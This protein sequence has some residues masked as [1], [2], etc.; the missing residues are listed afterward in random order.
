M[1]R[2]PRPNIASN[3]LANGVGMV[4]KTRIVVCRAAI[5]ATLNDAAAEW[6]EVGF[7][8]VGEFFFEE[9]CQLPGTFVIGGFADFGLG[10]DMEEKLFDVLAFD[11][12]F[13]RGPAEER[14]A[15]RQELVFAETSVAASG[16]VF[17]HD[18]LGHEA[19]LP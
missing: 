10:L 9:F 16:H 12:D 13:L 8:I 19:G 18:P 1:L 6:I 4:D 3:A 17:A 11:L 14:A 15:G 7:E 5:H 2:V